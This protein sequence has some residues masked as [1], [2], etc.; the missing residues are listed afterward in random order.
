MKKAALLL[1][2]S[3]NP[4]HTEHEKREKSQGNK[5]FVATLAGENIDG[6]SS[7]DAVDTRSHYSTGKSRDDGAA[8][9]SAPAD[10]GVPA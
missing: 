7:K 1:A 9:N 10:G 2:I 3:K 5:L 8:D 6:D 4:E